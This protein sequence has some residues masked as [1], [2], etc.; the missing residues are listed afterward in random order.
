MNPIKF[1]NALLELLKPAIWPFGSCLPPMPSLP[2]HSSVIPK[3]NKISAISCDIFGMSFLDKVILLHQD[4]A[5]RFGI[6]RNLGALSVYAGLFLDSFN[7]LCQAEVD[8]ALESLPFLV[9]ES[10]QESGRK[11]FRRHYKFFTLS[12][13]FP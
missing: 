11:G 5:I 1:Q 2:L 6:S 4:L 10:F 12:G 9:S 13:F 3:V 8:K 7:P